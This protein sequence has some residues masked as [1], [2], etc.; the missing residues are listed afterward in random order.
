MT[1]HVYD[2]GWSMKGRCYRRSK[3]EVAIFVAVREGSSLFPHGGVYDLYFS[4]CLSV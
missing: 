3:I 2:S 1:S 4:K